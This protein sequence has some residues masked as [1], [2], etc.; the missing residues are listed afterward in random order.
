MTV[1]IPGGDT[2]E[3]DAYNQPIIAP[4]ST[5]VV[6][7][8]VDPASSMDGPD[9]DTQQIISRYR[10][11]MKLP[12]DVDPAVIEQVTWR[13]NTLTVDGRIQP[14][15]IRGRISHHEFVSERVT[16]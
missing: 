14:Q 4:P 12:A 13:G 15:M 3:R 2:G 9:S 16:G 8:Q 7:A 6:P 11:M 1:T 5:Q 10:V